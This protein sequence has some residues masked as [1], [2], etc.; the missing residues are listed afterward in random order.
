MLTQDE[1]MI[2]LPS[3]TNSRGKTLIESVHKIQEDDDRAPILT[4]SAHDVKSDW[5]RN[6]YLFVR[7][8]RCEIPGL[9][10]SLPRY[11]ELPKPGLLAAMHTSLLDDR[12]VMAAAVRLGDPL[13]LMWASPRL[14]RDYDIVKIA[15]VANPYSLL[16]ACPE[17]VQRNP[18]LVSMA[19]QRGLE[20]GR[21]LCEMIGFKA[22]E[23]SDREMIRVFVE[24]CERA[25]LHLPATLRDDDEVLSWAIRGAFPATALRVASRRLRS[26][27]AIVMEAVQKCG[28]ALRWASLELCD[29]SAVVLAA[30]EQDPRA[31]RWASKRLRETNRELVLY[32]VSRDGETV[33]YAESIFC[34]DKEIM[35]SAVKSNGSALR[36]AEGGLDGDIEIV[37]IAI[38]NHPD[39][40]V[41]ASENI[42]GNKEVVSLAVEQFPLSIRHVTANLRNNTAIVK[43]AVSLDGNALRYASSGLKS[44]PEI[45]DA[46]VSNDGHALVYIPD[47]LKH[48][49]SVV[50]R[51]LSSQSHS[52]PDKALS[53]INLNKL[54]Q[55][56][57]EEATIAQKKTVAQMAVRLSG[58]NLSELP[59]EFRANPEIVL[60]AVRNNGKALRHSM[61]PDTRFKREGFHEL[62]VKERSGR[63][64]GGPPLF[65]DLPPD[66][67]GPV[68]SATEIVA[69]AL[70][71]SWSAAQYAP[72]ASLRDVNQVQ[73]IISECPDGWRALQW[74][75]MD[76]RT[77]RGLMRLAVTH[78]PNG[79]A[80]KDFCLS[81]RDEVQSVMN[82]VV[83]IQ[84]LA[85]RY[86]SLRLRGDEKIVREAVDRDGRSLEWATLTLRDNRKIV[87]RAINSKKGGGREAFKF[88]SLRLRKC[89]KVLNILA[90]NSFS[91][92]NDTTCEQNLDETP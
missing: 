27:R 53:C 56:N 34:Q 76:L 86:V 60:D 1:K 24:T 45:V 59:H 28:E 88:A 9:S 8:L 32:A 69:T 57:G 61:V 11:S 71:T 65:P 4:L 92:T 89:P 67:H 23:P 50:E 70:K 85:L 87:V 20:T 46:A 2:L 14:Q 30:V 29:D 81:L 74:L 18:D 36:F 68:V 3:Q 91:T 22:P 19:F 35:R 48:R 41:W 62:G 47:D 55:S 83:N 51:A 39:A 26:D 49:L 5:E 73:Q 25:F 37:K 64:C 15:I 31:L 75:S 79:E 80:L 40:L 72:L 38:A 90:K 54:V 66:N 13:S 7:Q 33:Q 77:H 16:W 10:E 84:P 17:L 21:P 42:R 82:D 58:E 52:A 6:R 43:K 78:S 63:T 12:E 44:S